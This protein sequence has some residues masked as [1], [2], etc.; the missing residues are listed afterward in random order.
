[1]PKGT[2]KIKFSKGFGNNIF[3]YVFG[4][5]L[6]E[7][8]NLNFDHDA[9]PALGIRE[10]R[11]P[12]NRKLKTV[13][14]S[15]KNNL[16]AKKY[17]VNHAQYFEPREEPCNFDFSRYMF[18]YEDYTLYSPHIEKIKG[19]FP[20]VK[21]S[22]TI[23]LVLHF[24]LEN[25][26]IWKTHYLNAIPVDVY[27]DVIKSNFDFDRLC[28]VSDSN[29][30]GYFNE[31]DIEGIR[32]KTAKMYVTNST[33]IIPVKKSIQYM[34]DLVDGLKEFDPVLHHSDK[35][36]DDFDFIRSFDKIMFKN[37]TFAWWAAALG[38]PSKVGVFQ[39][40]KPNKGK[41][42]KNLGRADFPGWF[43]WGS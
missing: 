4:R 23:D 20:I 15:A 16:E 42:N 36:I 32:S 41:R 17:D 27:R 5:L 3:Q 33:D 14:F 28:I 43:G 22:N 24:R 13:K 40:W 8:L 18:Y 31:K 39:P 1:M 10:E 11:Y 25:R 9:I 6:S 34:N 29:K 26:I 7:H 30:W 21:K 35:F 38:S 37:S 2:L 19:W 12:F